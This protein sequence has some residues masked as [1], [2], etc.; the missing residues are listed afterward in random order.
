MKKSK[1]RKNFTIMKNHQPNDNL[2]QIW[3]HLDNFLR[4]DIHVI[5][6]YQI[7]TYLHLFVWKK[8]S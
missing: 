2:S 7:K 1:N 4:D 5:F 8:I 6:C 3:F